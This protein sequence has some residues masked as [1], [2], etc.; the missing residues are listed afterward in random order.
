MKSATRGKARW[1]NRSQVTF[2]LARG[3]FMLLDE[4][5]RIVVAARLTPKEVIDICSAAFNYGV[6]DDP[7]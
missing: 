2:R 3:G 6:S 5:D 4:R 7:R 1:A